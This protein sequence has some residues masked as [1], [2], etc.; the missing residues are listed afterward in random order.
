MIQKF[1]GHGFSCEKS[2]FDLYWYFKS[3]KFDKPCDELHTAKEKESA[4]LTLTFFDKSDNRFELN[5][6]FDELL[7]P[8]NEIIDDTLSTKSDQVCFLRVLPIQKFGGMLSKQSDQWI[9][10]GKF[11]LS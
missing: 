3:C 11:V 6:G 7:V 2:V 8:G 5:I 9:I 1:D 4:N 10:G